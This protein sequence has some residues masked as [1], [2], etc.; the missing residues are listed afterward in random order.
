MSLQLTF[1]YIN[2]AVITLDAVDPNTTIRALKL[3][4]CMHSRCQAISPTPYALQ[5]GGVKISKEREEE[6]V[7]QV[8][9][10]DGGTYDLKIRHDGLTDREANRRHNTAHLAHFSS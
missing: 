6:T 3:D 4:V 1:N 9:L 8:G 5:V 2:Q 10:Q 7:A